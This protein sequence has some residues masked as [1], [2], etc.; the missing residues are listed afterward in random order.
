MQRFSGFQ[1]S[2][3]AAALKNLTLGICAFAV[4]AQA[5]TVPEG[6]DHATQK[7]YNAWDMA[8]QADV[9]PLLWTHNL[10]AAA[11][12]NGVMSAPPLPQPPPA[13][14]AVLRLWETHT[15]A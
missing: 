4:Q 7:L 12:N 13:P 14:A 15:H 10:A 2:A 6:A 8:T 3:V 5:Q 9:F 11:V 1:L